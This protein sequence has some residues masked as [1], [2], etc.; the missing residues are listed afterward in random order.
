MATSPRYVIIGLLSVCSL[1]AG[2][3]GW[4]GFSVL[5][6]F[7]G[8][9]KK[10]EATTAPVTHLLITWRNEV[11]FPPDVV[12][13]GRPLPGLAGRLFLFSGDNGFPVRGDGEVQVELYDISDLPRAERASLVAG[14]PTDGSKKLLERWC[15]DPE[16][17]KTLF[18][19]D[20]IG[21]GYTLFLP[22][23]S[24]RP[25]IRQVALKVCYLPKNSTPI[26]GPTSIVTLNVDSAP[27]V[28]KQQ[29]T[30]GA[31]GTPRTT[32]LLGAP[33]ATPEIV[34]PAPQASP[35][36]AVSTRIPLPSSRTTAFGNLVPNSSQ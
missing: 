33:V 3:V 23:G 4:S 5:S 29:T 6:P 10:G 31:P 36:S 21:W 26:Y 32:G 16:S 1:A 30:P 11:M 2:C 7:D 22:W 14:A 18:Q 17:L 34:N 35:T 13:Q 25:D 20:R 27:V 8:G 9:S 12:H 24:Y 15:F 19:Q 28:E